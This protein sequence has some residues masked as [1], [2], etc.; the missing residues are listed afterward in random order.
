M[1]AVQRTPG[2]WSSGRCG[3]EL[4]NPQPP[5]C[6]EEAVPAADRKQDI[7]LNKAS[8]R[9][10]ME[11]RLQWLRQQY[12]AEGAMT[13]R[14]GLEMGRFA[15]SAKTIA[16]ASADPKPHHI[17]VYTLHNSIFWCMPHGR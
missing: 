12:K 15:S 14:G 10:K 16:E 1:E 5:A 17:S 3:M 4:A 9:S 8:K 2:V 7:G 11:Q 13:T 6:G